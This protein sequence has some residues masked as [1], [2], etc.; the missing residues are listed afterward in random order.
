[1]NQQQKVDL[2]ATTPFVSE[3]G[4]HVFQEAIILRKISKFLAGTTEDGI[5]PIPVFIDVKTGKIATELLPKELRTEYATLQNPNLKTPV[6][7]PRF[8]SN[9]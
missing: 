7:G 1:M 3:D 4:N 9:E 6:S 2:K 8:D 5:I